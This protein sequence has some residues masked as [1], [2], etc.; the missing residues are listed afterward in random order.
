MVTDVE[1][2][3]VDDKFEILLTNL[4]HSKYIKITKRVANIN[5]LPQCHQYL[6]AVTI[7]KSPTSLSP[8]FDI[9]PDLFLEAD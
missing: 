9:R 8:K 2:K 7:I 6:R 1:T 4:L 5:I 3:C